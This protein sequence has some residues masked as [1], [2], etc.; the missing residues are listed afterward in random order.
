MRENKDSGAKGQCPGLVSLK[1]GVEELVSP[2]EPDLIQSLLFSH[3]VVI[4]SGD[5]EGSCFS[6]SRR[7]EKAGQ[8]N[9]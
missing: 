3:L 4:Y 7:V 9:V 1:V 8:G 5:R 2:L 6:L